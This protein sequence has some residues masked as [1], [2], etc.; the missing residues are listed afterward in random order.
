MSGGGGRI[1]SENGDECRMGGGGLTKFLPTGGG[2]PPV[3]Q[4]KTLPLCHISFPLSDFF[5]QMFQ[6]LLFLCKIIVCANWN[7]LVL[8]F[9]FSS[10]ISAYEFQT[11]LLHTMLRTEETFFSLAESCKRNCL[12]I[13]DRGAMDAT[14]CELFSFSICSGHL[15]WRYSTSVLGRG[16]HPHWVA[17]K[18]KKKGG[19]WF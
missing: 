2:G 7:Y 5:Y 9:Q 1:W 16:E 14:A 17:G 8:N 18:A 15:C 19:G 3:S 6:K 13:C 12:V 11:N 4:G 10:H